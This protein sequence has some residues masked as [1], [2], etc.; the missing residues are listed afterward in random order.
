MKS[1]IKNKG[2][3]EEKNKGGF[4]E[5]RLKCISTM[6]QINTI[7]IKGKNYS[8]VKDHATF[9]KIFS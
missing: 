7:P 1:E 5:R 9:F 4:K 6:N 8:M 2:N 3:T